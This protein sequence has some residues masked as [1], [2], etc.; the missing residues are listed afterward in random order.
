MLE[1]TKLSDEDVWKIVKDL[2]KK[3]LYKHDDPKCDGAFLFNNEVDYNTYHIKDLTN[4]LADKLKLN[5]TYETNENVSY[6]TLQTAAEMFLYLNYCPYKLDQSHDHSLDENGKSFWSLMNH[7]LK[8]ETPKDIILA[9]TVLQKTPIMRLKA[10]TQKIFRRVM[11]RI[12]LLQFEQIQM[13]TGNCLVNG[14]SGNCGNKINFDEKKLKVLCKFFSS[15]HK[16]S[17]HFSFEINSQHA[18]STS[19][20]HY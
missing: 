7:V 18:N 20:T 16:R 6:K 13:I 19:C 15:K 4:E 17:I 10:A 14:T 1:M 9:L 11:E 8:T 3:F 5:T 2:R 12:N